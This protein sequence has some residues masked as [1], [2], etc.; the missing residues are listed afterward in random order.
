MD[1]ALNSPTYVELLKINETDFDI[2]HAAHHRSLDADLD[3]RNSLKDL[4]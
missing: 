2:F 4:E 3:V 1:C